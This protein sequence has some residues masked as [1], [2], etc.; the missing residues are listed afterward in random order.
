MDILTL[1]D[2]SPEGIVTANP[3][4]Y[5]QDQ[6]GSRWYKAS[7]SGSTGWAA[8]I[9]I[10]Q[11]ASDNLSANTIPFNGPSWGE[12]TDGKLVYLKS[13]SVAPSDVPSVINQE[14]SSGSPLE[15][16]NFPSTADSPGSPGDIAYGTVSGVEWLALYTGDGTSHSW[17]FAPFQTSYPT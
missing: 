13:G 8:L 11:V 14:S 12:T 4:C 16:V 1:P 6:H 17:I 2:R 5:F 15:T 3:G 10:L 7:G 9:V